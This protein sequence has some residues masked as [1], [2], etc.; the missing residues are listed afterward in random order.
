[1]CGL[2]LQTFYILQFL[3]VHA[4]WLNWSRCHLGA[5]I[6]IVPK[7][8]VG[9]GRL[10]GL[11]VYTPCTIDASVVCTCWVLPVTC[12]WDASFAYITKQNCED[13]LMSG[14]VHFAN[15]SNCCAVFARAVPNILFVF[16]SGRILLHKVDRIGSSGVR[17]KW[18]WLRMLM[19]GAA[20]STAS[21]THHECSWSWRLHAYSIHRYAASHS[22]SNY[23]YSI[24]CLAE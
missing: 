23:S 21:G 5:A 14:I 24:L 8:Q 4:K 18:E 10:G 1:M 19:L 15:P 16:Y 17:L 6:S 11:V 9:K 13:H 3:C 7:S 2:L 20:T 12:R 22:L